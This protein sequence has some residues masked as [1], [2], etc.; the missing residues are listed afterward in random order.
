MHNTNEFK[1]FTMSKIQSL[2]VEP[3]ERAGKGAS[4][5]VRREGKVPGVV[6]GAKEDPELVQV[7]RVPL[8]KAVQN[9]PFLSTIFEIEVNGRKQQVL[10]RDIHFHPVTDE[11]IHVD[12]LRLVKGSTIV[13]EVPVHFTN[14]EKSPGIKRGGVLNIVRH[15]VELECPID[16]IPEYLEVNLDGLDI[17]DSVHISAVTL[18]EG[19][20]PTIERDFTIATIVA[21]SGLRSE[22]ASAEGEDE[23][24]E[25]EDEE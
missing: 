16:A 4:R 15:E 2:A 6:Y 19:V 20:K 12:F 17:N 18:P 1:D 10:P 7:A 8:I 9:N 5:A 23:E 13:V 14:Q 21:P 24:A 22:A 25:G 11:P 3:R